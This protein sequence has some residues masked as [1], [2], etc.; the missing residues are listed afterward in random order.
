MR[1]S[2]ESHRRCP[3]SCVAAFQV[4]C[5]TTQRTS[6]ASTQSP[7]RRWRTGLR[8]GSKPATCG[9]LALRAGRLRRGHISDL[10]GRGNTA[11]PIEAYGRSPV[12]FTDS[13][14]PELSEGIE[15]APEASQSGAGLPGFVDDR[16][17]TRTSNGS[18]TNR[19]GA[20]DLYRE[21][22][23]PADTRACT[24]SG[25]T[26]MRLRRDCHESKQKTYVSGLY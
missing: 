20:L 25:L 18:T 24:G 21:C 19:W 12:A 5:A 6:L 17:G 15:H 16:V 9:T 10:P 11:Y 4:L 7:S 13:F 14:H 2:A 8:G 26:S 3:R 23:P 1:A 22:T